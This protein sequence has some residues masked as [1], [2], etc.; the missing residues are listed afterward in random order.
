MTG[1]NLLQSIASMGSH[2][3]SVLV[4]DDE[5]AFCDVVCE[6]LEAMGYQ[7]RFALNA[8][9][10]LV[11]L[12]FYSPDVILT[13]VMMPDIDGLSFIRHL[14]SQAQWRSTPVVIISAKSSQEDR[15]QALES[16]ANDF[17]GKPFSAQDLEDLVERILDCTTSKLDL[18]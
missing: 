16:G 11:M 5:P 10:A 17:L 18:A 7:A 14:R 3:G 15:R 6:I 12:S 1:E 8:S 4:V 13:D 9:E 2:K